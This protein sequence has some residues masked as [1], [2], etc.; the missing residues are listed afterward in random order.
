M[1]AKDTVE[2]AKQ[3]AYSDSIENGVPS[4]FQIDYA[5]EVAVRLSGIVEADANIVHVGAY[6]MDCALGVAYKQRRLADH[7]NMSHKKAKEFLGSFKDITQSEKESILG[8]VLEHHGM[9]QFSSLEAEV[10]CNADCYK[11]LSVKGV[12]GGIAHMRDMEVEQLIQI[13]K[14]KADEKWGALSLDVC[15]EELKDQ[16]DSV[17]RLLGSYTGR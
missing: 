9:T 13:F 6:L 8:C 5:V 3:L 14:A 15:K 2:K 11:F 1:I 4:L 16:Y 10:V 17:K 12:I 7:I